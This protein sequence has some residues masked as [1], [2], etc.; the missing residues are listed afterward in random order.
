M[1]AIWP[2][3]A[4]EYFKKATGGNHIDMG[5]GVRVEG[6]Q[7]A[8]QKPQERNKVGKGFAVQKKLRHSDHIAYFVVKRVN[9][10][11]FKIVLYVY[12]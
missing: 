10:H 8:Q 2:P 9:L 1:A 6:Q 4:S 12:Y 11:I 5:H 7:T 3:V